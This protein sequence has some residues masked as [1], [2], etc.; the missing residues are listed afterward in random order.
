M[1]S[2]PE[3]WAG[4]LERLLRGDRLALAQLTRLINSFLARWNAYDFRDD[5]DDLI[6]EVLFAAAAALRDGRIRERSA[7]IGFL[8]STAR[9][10]F[11]DRL[12]AHLRLAE[13][14]ALPW[15][16][17]L[18]GPLEP[19]A[20]SASDE[21]RRD[22]REALARLPQKEREAI[23]A[24]HVEGRTYEDAASATGIPLGSLKRHLRDGLA[25]LRVEL[26]PVL[27]GRA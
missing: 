22:L 25:R 26:D 16:E 14:A 21:L 13:D 10:K 18:E 9:F 2:R 12:K 17:L 8:K 27:G 11:A 24:V 15:Q 5:W 1:T 6:Q 3:D 20:E 23:A 7:V 19:A 4:V